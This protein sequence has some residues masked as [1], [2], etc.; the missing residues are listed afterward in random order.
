MNGFGFASCRFCLHWNNKWIF[1]FNKCEIKGSTALENNEKEF[2]QVWYIECLVWSK[3]FNW[4]PIRLLLLLK[5]L[6]SLAHVPLESLREIRLVLLVF[7]LNDNVNQSWL[8]CTFFPALLV[9]YMY[10]LRIL[11]GSLDYLCVLWLA[12]VITLFLRYSVLK[13]GLTQS[14]SVVNKMR[15]TFDTKLKAAVFKMLWIEN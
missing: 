13:T 8:A 10:L 5:R 12:K 9:S 15:L 3:D 4:L 1:L 11:I 7:W 14:S 2:Y 6:S